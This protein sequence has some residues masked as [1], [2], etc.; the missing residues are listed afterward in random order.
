[1]H[2]Y[3]HTQQ[4][5]SDADKVMDSSSCPSWPEELDALDANDELTPLGRILAR[6]P[7]EP[8]LGKMM[9][10]GCIFQSVG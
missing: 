8:R 2:T 1:M 9:V 3:T 7:I 10:L 5:W 4:A 6:L